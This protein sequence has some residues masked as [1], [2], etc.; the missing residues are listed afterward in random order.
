M[1]RHALLAA[2]LAI[3]TRVAGHPLCLDDQPPN[4][5]QVLMFCP[6]AQDGACCDDAEEGDVEE[7]FEAAFDAANSPT[8][9][10]KALYKQ[11][12]VLHV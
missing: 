11:V 3:S 1:R 4:E 7:R 12:R 8:D 5:S 6:E 2:F 9:E 10:C